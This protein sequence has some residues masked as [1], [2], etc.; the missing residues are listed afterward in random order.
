MLTLKPKNYFQN[1]KI[2]VKFDLIHLNCF[3]NAFTF[4]SIDKVV[5]YKN[6]T[7]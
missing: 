5:V 3:R 2:V 6:I 1:D 7:V 4:I